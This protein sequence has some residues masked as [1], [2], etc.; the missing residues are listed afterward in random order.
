MRNF[1]YVMA[2]LSMLAAIAFAF[3]GNLPAATLP[4]ALAIYL[5]FDE[6]AA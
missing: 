2:R 5:R 6:V 1:I 4:A 3:T